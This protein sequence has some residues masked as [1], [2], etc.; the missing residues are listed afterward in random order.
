MARGWQSTREALLN[1]V[2]SRWNYVANLSQID[3][4]SMPKVMGCGIATYYN[5][6]RDLERL[7]LGEIWAIERATGCELTVPFQQKN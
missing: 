7:T 4:K 5:R 3:N 2:K 6:K 1:E